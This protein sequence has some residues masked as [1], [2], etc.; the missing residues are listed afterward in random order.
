MNATETRNI[1]RNATH[2]INYQMYGEREKVCGIQT[3][4]Y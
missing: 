4:L 3:D 1:D 2:N